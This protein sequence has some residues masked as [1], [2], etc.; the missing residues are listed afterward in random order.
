MFLLRSGFTGVNVCRRNRTFHKDLRQWFLGSKSSVP[1]EYIYSPFPLLHNCNFVIVV[2]HFPLWYIQVHIEPAY[3][4]LCF[5]EV[6][7]KRKGSRC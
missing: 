7:P 5:P 2:E 3:Q 6:L 4:D 1:V